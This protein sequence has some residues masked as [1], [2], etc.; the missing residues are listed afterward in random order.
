M[1]LISLFIVELIDLRDD[2]KFKGRITTLHQDML[3]GRHDLQIGKLSVEIVHFRV[4]E[5]QN[6]RT[7]V[8]AVH[9]FIMV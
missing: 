2:P 3:V 7:M 9:P 6:G 1:F 5:T 4:T 8:Q